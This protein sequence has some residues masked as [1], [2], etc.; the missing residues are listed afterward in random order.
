MYTSIVIAG[1]ALKVLAVIGILKYLEEK[2][3]LKYVKNYVG[4]SAGAIMSL[5]LALGY[6]SNEIHKLVL[7]TLEDKNITT[8][9]PSEIFDIFDNYG[10]SNGDNLEILFNKIIMK[11]FQKN[12]L[13]F[14]EF[15]KATGKNLVICISNLTKEKHE[16]C[17]VDTTPNFSV[18]KAIR[19]SCSIPLMYS[20]VIL[21]DN[22]YLDGGL[23][24]NFPID[25]FSDHVLKD[26]LGI[27]II[28]T[29]YQKSDNF[30]NYI[31]FILNSLIEKFNTKSINNKDRNVITLEFEDDD[32]W[33]SISEVKISLTKDKLEKYISHGYQVAK[34]NLCIST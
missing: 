25:Y 17:S 24:N 5:L 26:I 9:N 6:N 13:S 22:I 19:I 21:N 10:L 27:N 12:D 2:D 18:A 30:I 34:D 32:N 7:Q 20:P 23:Y 29:N 33:F 11:K 15:A 8:F 14:I 31:R 1:G 3:L 28:T 16:Y 4:T